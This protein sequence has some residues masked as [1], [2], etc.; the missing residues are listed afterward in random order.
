M[1]WSN[2]TNLTFLKSGNVYEKVGGGS[3]TTNLLEIKNGVL[4]TKESYASMTKFKGWIGYISL[5][6]LYQ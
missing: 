4:I 5:C 6:Y 3:K 1:E 2:I